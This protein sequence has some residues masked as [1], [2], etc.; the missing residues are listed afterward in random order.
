MKIDLE[1]EINCKVRRV[2]NYDN[3][4]FD[5]IIRLGEVENYI[6]AEPIKSDIHINTF[7]IAMYKTGSQNFFI[8]GKPYQCDSNQMIIIKPNEEHGTGE[9]V[10]KISHFYYFLISLQE[11]D[12]LFFI[13]DEYETKYI[14]DTLFSI[15]KRTFNMTGEQLVMCKEIL[16]IYFSENPFKSKLILSYTLRLIISIVT[17]I[18]NEKNRQY[19]ISYNDYCYWTMREYIS[20]NIS[21]KISVSNLAK[22]SNL[23][24]SR[25]HQIFALYGTS[26]H[27]YI[28]SEKV[29]Y[30]KKLL[31]DSDMS[32]T[33]IAFKL[34]F[35]SSQHFSTVFRKHELMAPTEYRKK[36]CSKLTQ[37]NNN[38]NVKTG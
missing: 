35:S 8:E 18:G 13:F 28:L 1:P 25:V 16:D 15:D 36:C 17:D 2:M 33:E 24:E 23:S 10:E 38:P 22:F 21:K 26:V 29:N 19:S 6:S 27:K 9:Y 5:H 37:N 12:K 20:E 32:I 11:I 14:K 7:E 31:L 3:L 4:N 30:A 34:D